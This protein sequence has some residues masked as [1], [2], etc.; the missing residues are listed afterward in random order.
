MTVY[1]EEEEVVVPAEEGEEEEGERPNYKKISSRP[2]KKEIE[3]HMTT[4][5][6]LKPG[7]RTA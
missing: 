1:C 7:A 5:I 2:T 3:E 6:P 4:H